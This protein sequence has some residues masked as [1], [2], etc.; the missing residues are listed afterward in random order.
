MTPYTRQI[1]EFLVCWAV[2]VLYPYCLLNHSPGLKYQFWQEG[3]RLGFT[4]VPGLHWRCSQVSF[5]Q[6]RN[7][8]IFYFVVT[9]SRIRT[10]FFFFF[11]TMLETLTWYLS[12]VW[13][14]T[15]SKQY[16]Q[17]AQNLSVY[18][19]REDWISPKHHFACT[20]HFAFWSREIYQQFFDQQFVFNHEALTTP[21]LPSPLISLNFCRTNC[22]IWFLK[23]NWNQVR[24]ICLPVHHLT[25][26]LCMYILFSFFT[27]TST[28]LPSTT[29][30]V[31]TF[32]LQFILISI[33]FSGEKKGI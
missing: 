33:F 4:S 29:S 23:S 12:E 9:V 5:L 24:F 2:Y 22:Q 1:R 14:D 26:G 20:C 16:F 6:Y 28:Y 8:T 3:M 15:S 7:Y 25:S 10:A 31:D 30:E 21:E 27:I 32:I 19:W 18:V 11:F 17:S 13:C